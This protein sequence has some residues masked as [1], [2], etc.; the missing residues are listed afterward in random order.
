MFKFLAIFHICGL[1]FIQF[2]SPSCNSSFK[3]YLNCIAEST[4]DPS[5]GKNLEDEFA[6]DFE[7]L[8]SRSFDPSRTSNNG[9]CVLSNAELKTDIFGDDGPLRNCPDCQKIAK[10]LKKKIFDAPEDVRLC[11]RLELADAVVDELQPCIARELNDPNFRVPPLPDFDEGSSSFQ[12]VILKAVSYRVM[13]YSRLYACGGVSVTR[14][15]ATQAALQNK[16]GLFKNHCG[17]SSSCK[18]KINPSCNDDFFKVEKATCKCMFV[19]KDEWHAKFEI[20]R[21]SIENFQSQDICSKS[22]KDAV[23]G[24]RYKLQ[25]ALRKC[26]PARDNLLATLSIDKAIDTAC[27]DFTKFDV[28]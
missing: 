26:V 7:I 4:G 24:W 5:K 25:S 17:L 18:Q 23:G 6:D 19:K 13:A 1:F 27:G 12:D 2:V 22:I 16:A 11:L 20:V 10:D 28:S 21:D 3:K 14:A 8:A 9:R 15:N